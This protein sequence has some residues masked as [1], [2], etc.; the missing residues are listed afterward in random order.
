M[1]FAPR[2]L[3]DDQKVERCSEL[4]NGSG[5]ERQIGQ[6]DLTSTNFAEIRVSDIQKALCNDLQLCTVGFYRNISAVP[7]LF[8]DVPFPSIWNEG[9]ESVRP[10]RS[11]RLPAVIALDG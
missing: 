6:T 1:D 7:R 4:Q 5:T 2:R 10:S 3:T 9:I 11:T 8:H